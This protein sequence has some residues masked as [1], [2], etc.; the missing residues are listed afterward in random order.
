MMY[1]KV[2]RIK[3]PLTINIPISVPLLGF[4]AARRHSV[5]QRSGGITP[6]LNS[7]RKINKI[8]V[9]WSIRFKGLYDTKE[10]LLLVLKM[11]DNH[12]C[13]LY[14]HHILKYGG[15]IFPYFDYDERNRRLDIIKADKNVKKARVARQLA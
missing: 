15:N 13:N 2:C 8:S 10:I 7:D 5:S 4:P 11:A 1:P 14:F 12:L 6:P 3:T 9:H